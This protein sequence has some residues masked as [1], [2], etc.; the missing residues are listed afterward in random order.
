M[1]LYLDLT[2][3][4]DSQ[5]QRKTLIHITELCILPKL[6]VQSSEPHFLGRRNHTHSHCCWDE[7]GSLVLEA[8]SRPP[9]HHGFPLAMLPSGFPVL[10]PTENTA[11]TLSGGP[12]L[13]M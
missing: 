11:E 4:S 2:P 6:G 8:D 9:P 1:V 5:G 10:K 3:S 13:Q 7:P 12:L